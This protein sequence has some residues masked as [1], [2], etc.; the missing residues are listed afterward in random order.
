ML[1]HVPSIDSVDNQG[2]TPLMIAAVN[3]KL[4][5]VKYLLKQGADPSLQTNDGWNV[6]HYASH[7]GNP[8]VIELMLSH[9]LSI[10]SINSEGVTLLMIAAAY[11]KLQAVKYLL[12]QGADLSL[13]DNDGCNVLHCASGSGNVAIMEEILSYRIDIELET[14]LVKRRLWLLRVVVNPR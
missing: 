11:D 2:A 5:A 4:Q 14:I 10:D 1:S 9:V 3:D 8:E 13:Q 7:G 6:L 12:K